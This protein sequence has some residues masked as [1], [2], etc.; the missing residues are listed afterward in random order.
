MLFRSAVGGLMRLPFSAAAMSLV[1][2]AGQMT[3]PAAGLAVF[4]E[5][6]L[7]AQAEQFT[8]SSVSLVTRPQRWL[9]A[10][11]SSW[12]L[13][14]FDLARSAGSRTVKKISGLAAS[15]LKDRQWRPTRWGVGVFL[16]ANLLGLNVWAWQQNTQSAATRTA[17]QNS[18]TQTFPNVKVVVDAPLQMQREVNQL[19]QASG[20]VG[21]GDFEAMLAALAAAAPAGVGG[22]GGGS[23][24]RAS[25]IEFSNG[26]LRVKGFVNNADD[27]QSTAASLK[28]KGYVGQ[29]DGGIYVVKLADKAAP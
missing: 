20:A 2:S 3:G 28:A 13:A 21:R 9:D 12:D 24:G 4:S 27:S 25:S 8:Q 10:A 22:A 26:E 17:I 7:A 14:Q 19:R 1:P 11:G 23:P 16:A 18:L 6:A 29:L 15:L 5:P